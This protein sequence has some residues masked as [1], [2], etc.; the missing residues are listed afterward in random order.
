[1]SAWSGERTAAAVPTQ[2]ARVGDPQFHALAARTLAL[3][4]QRQV[5]AELGL[6]DHR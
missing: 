5:L 4:V 6:Q 2:S 1:M 3:A